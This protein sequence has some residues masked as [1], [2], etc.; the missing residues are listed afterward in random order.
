MA[1]ALTL[2]GVLGVGAWLRP[3]PDGYGTHTQLGMYPCG[4]A[5]SMGKPCPTCG[6]TTAFACAAHMDLLG[7]A[8]AQPMGMLLCLATAMGFWLALHVAV[9]G[10][11]VGWAVARLLTPGLAWTLLGMLLAAWAYKVATWNGPPGILQ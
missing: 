5:A 2:L 9:T 3:S 1:L 11:R 8:R 6:M 4:W 10:S 7:S